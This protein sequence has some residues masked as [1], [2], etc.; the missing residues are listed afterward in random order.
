VEGNKALAKNYTH[1]YS[2]LVSQYY[3]WQK[4]NMTR[5][6]KLDKISLA[7]IWQNQHKS[8]KNKLGTVIID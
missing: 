7:H 3:E 8:N 6:N 4:R 5:K 1:R 2:R